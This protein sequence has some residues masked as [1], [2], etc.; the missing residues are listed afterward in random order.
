MWMPLVG[1]GWSLQE[2]GRLLE[3]NARIVVACLAKK[4][5]G[6]FSS[7]LSEYIA[8]R[9]GL[10]FVVLCDLK[11][12]H[13]ESDAVNVTSV[14]NER[15]TL[16]EARRYCSSFVTDFLRNLQSCSLVWES[17]GSPFRPSSFEF[18]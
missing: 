1:Q 11:V 4:I 15:C 10:E 14:V 18:Y 12:Q 8:L 7:H 5:H 9:K 17:C 2:L 6:M 3:L 16:G 13:V